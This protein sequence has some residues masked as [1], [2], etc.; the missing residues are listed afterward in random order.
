VDHT[1]RLR[2]SDSFMVGTTKLSLHRI[3]ADRH[4]VLKVASGGA[5]R[6]V[7]LNLGVP[8]QLEPTVSVALDP[9]TSRASM[10]VVLVVSAPPEVEVTPPR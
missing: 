5:S 6:T 8:L 3:K 9:N 7:E 4:V 2:S 1:L 10:S